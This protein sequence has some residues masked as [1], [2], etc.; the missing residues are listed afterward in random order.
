MIQYLIAGSDNFY[1]KSIPKITYPVI[2]LLTH[3]SLVTP[4]GDSDMGQYWRRQWLGA[5]QH[6]TITWNNIDLSSMRFCLTANFTGNA[7]D[8]NSSNEFEKYLF[9]KYY[10]ISQI[11]IISFINVDTKM[12]SHWCRTSHC[13]DQRIVRSFCLRNEIS[14]SDETSHI[15][16]AMITRSNIRYYFI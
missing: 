1:L 2:T 11:S 14:Y 10:H 5:R 8:I 6:Q 16:G 13:K 15:L 3:C 12:L 9:L 7:W 4:Y